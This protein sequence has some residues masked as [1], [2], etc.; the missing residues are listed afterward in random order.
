MELP[1]EYNWKAEEKKWQKY[2]I[3]KK[4]FAF[5]PK[6][7]KKIYS[8]D[9][10]PPTVSG[11]MHLGHAFSYSHIDFIARY[12]RMTSYNVFFP[13][14]FDD[15]GLATELFVEKLT[16]KTAEQV[17]RE[18][19][20]ELCLKNTVEAEKEMLTSWQSIGMSCDWNIFYRTISKD[21]QKIS[22]KAFIDLYK[23]GRA[24]RKEDPAIWCTKCRT[25]I[26]QAE[27]E[28]VEQE[29]TFYYLR[30][31]V[32]SLKKDITIATTRPEFFTACVA[33]FVNP[34]D[35]R[36]KEFIGKKAMLH[37]IDREIPIIASENANPEKGTGAVYI[38]TFGDYEDVIW[39]KSEKLPVIQMLNPDGRLNENAGKYSGL[40]LKEAKEKI[41][42]DLKMVGALVKEEKIK[43]I[44]NV[45]E[46]CGT[47]AE[48]IVAKQWF[49][50][51]L[52]LRETFL[53]S[54]AKIKWH[55]SYMFHRLEHWIKGLKWDWCV[56][57]Q[58]YFGIPIPVW[59]CAKCGT[60][61]LPDEKVLPI[62]PL[63]DKPKK[64]CAE[65]SSK[66]FI[67]EKDVFDTWVTSSHT[68]EIAAGLVDKKLFSK[69]FPMDLRPQAHDI[70]NFWLFY[71]LAK[72]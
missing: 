68:P 45:H 17:G 16:G 65:C 13:W 31:N 72:S 40:K 28:D 70:I 2:W 24:Y 62:N 10:P 9:T 21:V 35:S 33:I 15:N 23:Q 12:R 56:S 19:F 51:Y 7:N 41:I 57:R 3:E 29:S 52:D 30:F 46:R 6:S 26:A 44:V 48:Y 42:N 50:K 8:I 47:P 11:K 14:G 34:K 59:Y 60:V 69:L 53:Q 55:P 4:I 36:Y 1:K 5:N 64:K 32:P 20:I 39:V 63:V 43:N 38:C 25:A 71:T 22:Q 66:E 27:L 49:I 61:L 18:K 54:G 58:R 37:L 67:P